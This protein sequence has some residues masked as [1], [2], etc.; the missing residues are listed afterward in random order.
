M[1]YLLPDTSEC[2][3]HDFNFVYIS[4]G[5]TCSTVTFAGRDEMSKCLTVA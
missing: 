4:V 2:A 3:P 1:S 5:P